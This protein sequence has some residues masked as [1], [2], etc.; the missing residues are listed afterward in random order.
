MYY[1]ADRDAEK[2]VQQ[3]QTAIGVA[4]PNGLMS[5]VTSGYDSSSLSGISGPNIT[6]TELESS[7]RAVEFAFKK[8]L[9]L[10][11]IESSDSF[12]I[13]SHLPDDSSSLYD[14]LSLQK[15]AISDQHH[16]NSN[17]GIHLLGSVIPPEELSLYYLDPQGEIQGP[18]L[19]ID[20]IRWFEQGYYGTELLVCLSDAPV[21]SPF[22]ELAD[23]MPHLRNRSRSVSGGNLVTNLEPSDVTG[24][25]FE[26]NITNLTSAH[27]YK[28]Y[29][30]INDQKCASS[31]SNATSGVNVNHGYQSELYFSDDHKFQ[32]FVTEDDSKFSGIMLPSIV[33][34]YCYLNCSSFDFVQKLAFP[35]GLNVAIVT[36]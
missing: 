26:E 33:C 22:Q 5:K 19:G 14:F 23:V 27:G 36:L 1:S 29:A 4:V 18:F 32:N 30:V 13:S 8:H 17:E 10:R 20:I 3:L 31:G 28:D 25:I 2:E 6:F 11:E 24:S 16:V 9:K 34:Q 21:G 35:P 7:D 12:E 15:T